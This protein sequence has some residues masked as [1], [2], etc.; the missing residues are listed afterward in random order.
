MAGL[1]VHPIVTA[2]ARGKLPRWAS[3]RP[4]RL[5]HQSRV[6]ALLERWAVEL[7]LDGRDRTRWAAAGWL[8]DSLRDGTDELLARLAPEWPAGLRHGPASARLLE[9]D[10]IDDRELLEAIRYHSVGRGGLGELG[11]FLYLADFLEP[12]RPYLPIERAFLSA[13]LPRDAAA[14]LRRVGELR[15]AMLVEAGCSLHPDT[16]NFWNELVGR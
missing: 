7:G 5:A 10:G 2:A 13:R 9:A 4:R 16:V 12:G 6:A 15:V 3:A 1:D 11:R 14:V 8:H